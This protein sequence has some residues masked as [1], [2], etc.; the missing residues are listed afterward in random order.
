MVAQVL[1]Y[2]LSCYR[3]A[4]EKGNDDLDYLSGGRLPAERGLLDLSS[5]PHRFA[6]VCGMH[7]SGARGY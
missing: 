2:S 4:L 5:L 3:L 6:D 1:A 7:N